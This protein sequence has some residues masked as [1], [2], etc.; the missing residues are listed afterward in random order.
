MLKNRKIGRKKW[1]TVVEDYES[2]SSWHAAV[3]SFRRC[4]QTKSQGAQLEVAAT[5]IDPEVYLYHLLQKYQSRGARQ[6]PGSIH[7]EQSLRRG[8]KLQ[9]GKRILSKMNSWCCQKEQSSWEGPSAGPGAGSL[10]FSEHAE[11]PCSQAGPPLFTLRC[12]RSSLIFKL[13]AVFQG[14]Q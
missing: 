12:L 3:Q 11:Q 13:T 4:H 8:K 10:S 1:N 14:F 7:T 9:Q 5:C 6:T 2:E